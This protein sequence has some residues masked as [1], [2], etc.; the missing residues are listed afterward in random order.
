MSESATA[1]SHANI[2]NLVMRTSSRITHDPMRTIA[3]TLVQKLRWTMLTAL[4]AATPAAAGN[5]SLDLTAESELTDGALEVQLEIHNSGDEGAHSI[6]PTLYFRGQ[7]VTGDDHPLLE[8]FDSWDTRI[9]LPVDDS[10]SGRW[11]YRVVVDYEDANGH[12]YHA[13]HVATVFGGRAPP[14]KLA[15]LDISAPSLAPTGT[16]V[17]ETR[18]KNLSGAARTVDLRV[19]LPDGI[20]L[21]QPVPPFGLTGWE[22]RSVAASLVNRAVQMDGHYA[23]FVSVEYDDGEI[24]HAVVAPASL[25]V[26][27]GR[28][29][30]EGNSA[31]FWGWA[32]VAALAIVW[33][34]PALW[35]RIRRRG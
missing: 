22:E 28:P 2:S 33:A 30:S 21:E 17:L 11:P 1:A 14:S 35:R 9:T 34:A 8:A 6:R 25:E 3:A 5:I 4:L 19:H 7:I 20:Q 24:H 27:A 26:T 32:A 12:P 18:V 10:L 29:D 13:L 23:V 31:L 16:G 15:V